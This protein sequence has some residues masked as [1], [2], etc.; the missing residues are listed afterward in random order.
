MADA[1]PLLIVKTATSYDDLPDLCAKRGDE[2]AW[3]REACGLSQDDVLAVDA[4]KGAV[5]PDPSD[6]RGAIITGSVD[7]ISDDLPWLGPLENWVTRAIDHKLP[8]LGVCFGHHLLAHVLGGAV[9]PNP[10]GAEFGC[11]PMQATRAAEADALFE[12][13]PSHFNMHVFHYE[14]VLKC[15]AN[16]TRLV[17][18]DHDSNH[19]LRYA[20]HIWGTQFHPEF[21][22]EI[23]G[24]AIKAYQADMIKA[25]YDIAQLRQRSVEETIGRKLLRRFADL[26]NERSVI[27]G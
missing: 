16:A 22:A 21:D 1:K 4:Y 25:G 26:T 15:P 13:M 2:V 12:A 17:S 5:L 8:L 27:C 7:M 9:G 19:A 3:F 24:Q 6:V 20:D 18:N 14:S 23:M 10:N 11:V